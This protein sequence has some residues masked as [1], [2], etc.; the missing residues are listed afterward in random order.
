MAQISQKPGREPR[1]NVCIPMDCSLI[2]GVKARARMED[3]SFAGMLRE[4]VRDG[5]DKLSQ[6]AAS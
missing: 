3:R 4:I 5:M 6:P 1:A 2:A